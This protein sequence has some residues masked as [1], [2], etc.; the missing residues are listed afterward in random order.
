MNFVAKKTTSG[1]LFLLA[2]AAPNIAAAQAFAGLINDI[3]SIINT[4]LPVLAAL[5]LLAFFYGLVIYVYKADDE[6]GQEKG[7][8][9]MIAGIVAL[10]LMAAIG[11]IVNYIETQVLGGQSE[12]IDIENPIEDTTTGP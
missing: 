4:I 11:G 10:V 6:D 8:Q 7:R 2:L 12:N 9:T 3:E 5:A 1:F